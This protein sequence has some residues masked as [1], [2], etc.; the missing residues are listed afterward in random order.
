[1][2]EQYEKVLLN[3]EKKISDKGKIYSE[4]ISEGSK[5]ISD[6]KENKE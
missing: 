4:I 5:I 3:M 2:N 6:M 1:M